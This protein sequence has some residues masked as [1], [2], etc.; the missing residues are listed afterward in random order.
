MMFLLSL[1]NRQDLL[2]M[3]HSPLSPYFFPQ[4]PC[5]SVGVDHDGSSSITN[6]SISCGFHCISL[7]CIRKVQEEMVLCYPGEKRWFQQFSDSAEAINTRSKCH[8]RFCWEPILPRWTWWLF[9]IWFSQFKT[10]YGRPSRLISLVRDIIWYCGLDNLK[11]ICSL[12]EK[13]PW[14]HLLLG[15]ASKRRPTY[16]LMVLTATRL[17]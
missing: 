13:G 9:L 11:N 4:C 10:L 16:K 2:I 12:S 15:P 1:K 3:L 17:L 5:Q 7:H 6:H 14:Q 8:W